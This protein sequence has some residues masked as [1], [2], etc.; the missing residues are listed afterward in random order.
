M[1]SWSDN[2]IMGKMMNDDKTKYCRKVESIMKQTIV[3]IAVC[4]LSSSIF[5]LAT[6]TYN[7]LKQYLCHEYHTSSIKVPTLAISG[8]V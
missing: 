8:K 5:T 4:T 2:K 6:N 1:W 7:P 3:Y